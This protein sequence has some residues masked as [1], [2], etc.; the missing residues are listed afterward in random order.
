MKKTTILLAAAISAISASA[1]VT[2]SGVSAQQRWPWNNLVDVDFEIQ[3][4][5][6]GEAFAIGVEAEWAGGAKKVVGTTFTTEPVASGGASRITW[7]FGADC[8]N[9]VAADC[10]ISVTATPISDDAAIYM[11]IDLSGGSS[12]TAW[13]VRYTLTP[14]AHV[15]G[16][17]GEPCQTTELWLRRVCAKGRT[18]RVNSYNVAASGVYAQ[19][20]NDFYM[21]I[22]EITQQQWYQ[23]TGTWMDCKFSKENCRASRP[24]DYCRINDLFG[25]WAW[26]DDKNPTSTSVMQKLRDRTGVSTIG[27]PTEAQWQ[28]AVAGGP[29]ASEVDRYGPANDIAR[30]SGTNAGGVPTASECADCD[31]TRGT[32]FVGT[33]EPNS[34]GLYDM[35]GNVAEIIADP[36]MSYG[37]LSTYYKTTLGVGDS[38]SNPALEPE[39]APQDVAKN[40]PGYERTHAL[41]CFK[42]S[43][44]NATEGNLTY[45]TKS[46]TGYTDRGTG[47]G[48]RLAVTCTK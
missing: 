33:Y 19:Q 21:A 48:F 34:L 5:A 26:P 4:A 29:M 43:G 27:L 38:T 30:Y 40:Q 7:D 6:A 1:A 31:E 47:L 46:Y 15:K 37:N 36:Y 41:V 18:F 8:P 13:P 35:L 39:G 42:G 32:A 9:T 3:G 17:S 10:R 16:A 22:F 45:F 14:P 24:L 2:V 28:Y 11:V 12:A 25:T 23:M 20:T 44:F